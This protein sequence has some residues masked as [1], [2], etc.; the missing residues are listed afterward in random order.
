[1][2]SPPVEVAALLQADAAEVPLGSGPWNARFGLTLAVRGAL[3]RLALQGTFA[4]DAGKTAFALGLEGQGLRAGPLQA[5]LP[6]GLDCELRSGR[7]RARLEGELT[8]T[9][10]RASLG[11]V[12]LGDGE[13]GPLLRVGAFT[14]H[15]TRPGPRALTVEELSLAG[16]EVAARRTGR[17]L[18]AA[19]LVF[20]PAPPEP[21]APPPPP[22][23]APPAAAPPPAP[24][25]KGPLDALRVE[26]LSLRV[27]RFQFLDE[28]VPDAKPF[29]VALHLRSEE[30]LQ[31]LVEGVEEMPALNF[32]LTGAAKPVVGA[33]DLKL[34]CAPMG[35]DPGLDLRILLEGIRGA[36]LTEAFPALRERLDG[37]GLEDGRLEARL[38]GALRARRRG[39]FGFDL[40][41]GFGL[42]AD[43]SGVTLRTGREGP[44]LA[45]LESVM[46]DVARVDDRQVRVREIEI[47]KPVGEV[48]Q[49]P[50]GVLFAGILWKSAPK[51]PATP[52]PASPAPASPPA[53]A[54]A[55]PESERELRID[56][57]SVQ[58]IDFR[59][60]DDSVK[61]TLFV[62][63]E[64][65]DLQ[66]RN[67]STRSKP[68]PVP[69]DFQLALRAGA[70]ELPPRESSMIGGLLSAVT[71][72]GQRKPS[73]P[74]RL[75][76]F[77]EITTRGRFALQPALRGWATI[78]VEGLELTGFR[79]LSDRAGV[80]LGDGV[81]TTKIDLQADGRS[82][83]VKSVSTFENLSLSEPAGGP[84]SS[85][86][87]LPAPLDT[88]L[89]VLDR[90]NGEHR[91][92]LDFTLQENQMSVG[93]ATEVLI[94]TLGKL[95]ADAIAR[96]PLRITSTV[97][98]TLTGLVGL[99]LPQQAA[100]AEPSREPIPVAF[101]PGDITLSPDERSRVRVAAERLKQDPLLGVT[102]RHQL[103]Q[104]DVPPVSIRANPDPAA[105]AE[106]RVRLLNERDE[107]E[108][109]RAELSGEVRAALAFADRAAAERAAGTIREVDG[110]RA[111]VETGLDN[112]TELLVPGA[113][114]RQ[115][116]RTRFGLRQLGDERLEA[117]HRALREAGIAEERIEVRRPSVRTVEGDD[118]GGVLLLLRR[119]R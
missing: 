24:L 99:A 61:P 91:V 75:P 36:G 70:V 92:P 95:I 40:S 41:E 93:A 50:E 16:V 55:P 59:Y 109:R 33:L 18:H 53:P 56:L 27:D 6:P 73:G 101:P 98:G 10:V 84:I 76:L 45:G 1:M 94:T 42:L 113:R 14:A 11:D 71:R 26:R 114:R 64:D 39:R 28:T 3:E 47:V 67:Y 89:F 19:G 30:P 4:E 63:L 90:G 82:I 43:L 107:L 8:K 86:L 118:G 38:R 87:R 97:T 79:G 65:L 83:R 25:A 103:H 96:S 104:A 32:R 54:P 49:R 102:L 46:V 106:L 5:Y 9:S 13:S 85:V 60:R 88:V 21:A 57:L 80:K 112:V 66:V 58:G 77:Q 12:E 48:H 37:T 68:A 7:L 22:P 62:P 110:Q 20:G 119:M 105:A 117:V 81:A 115:A 17:G 74:E 111:K 52:A 108:R 72:P 69:M 2:V 100:A 35:S 116:L 31:V 29:D 34:R 78:V 44:V 51:A 23:S 15:G